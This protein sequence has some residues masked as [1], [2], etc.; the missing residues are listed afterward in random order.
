MVGRGHF[1]QTGLAAMAMAAMTK[2]AEAD[3][4][5]EKS[6]YHKMIG[7]SVVV[8]AAVSAQLL[9]CCGQQC[10]LQEA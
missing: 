8:L 2:P 3:E 5:D 9:G 10:R 4:M 7:W 1:L 6:E